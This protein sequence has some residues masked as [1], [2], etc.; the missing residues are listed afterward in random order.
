MVK[1]VIPPPPPPRSL[2]LRSPPPP[3]PLSLFLRG[4]EPLALP[5]PPPALPGPPPPACPCCLGPMRSMCACSSCA[6]ARFPA[7]AAASSASTGHSSQQGTA[8]LSAHSTA[9]QGTAQLEQGSIRKREM[10]CS[11]AQLRVG[12]GLGG[13]SDLSCGDRPEPQHNQLHAQHTTGLCST[14]SGA[15]VSR[16]LLAPSPPPTGTGH[17]QLH[18]QTVSN[19]SM[20]NAKRG[21]ARV[22]PSPHTLLAHSQ[23]HGS[24]TPPHTTLQGHA[25]H[26]Q[27]TT[28]LNPVPHPPTLPY[29]P[30]PGGNSKPGLCSRSSSCCSGSS[31]TCG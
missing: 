28:H 20:T 23:G 26:P 7:D 10:A 9:Q 17:N 25:S 5:D 12:G 11:R 22:R 24:L 6:R 8:Q 29:P 16:T 30:A 31:S 19:E 2:F 3:L 14:R 15:E 27:Q 4:P 21:K 1:W 13:G 18:V